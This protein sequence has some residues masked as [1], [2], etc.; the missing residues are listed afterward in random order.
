MMKLETCI[1]LGRSSNSG[2]NFPTKFDIKLIIDDFSVSPTSLKRKYFVN[3]KEYTPVVGDKLYFLP[4]CNVP[5]FKLKEFLNNESATLVKNINKATV[6][7]MSADVFYN[8]MQQNDYC[9]RYEKEDVLAL[10]N[11]HDGDS[12]VI[13]A[14]KASTSKYVMSR[15]SIGNQGAISEVK[16][17]PEC[18]VKDQ[19]SYEQLI[20][21]ESATNMYNQD[22]ILKR[23][24]TG[25]VMSNEDYES[26]QRFF[27]SSDT[28]HHMVAMEMMANSDYQKSCVY[29]HLLILEY[30]DAIYV[31]KSKNHVNF[32][33]LLNFLKISDVHYHSIDKIFDSLIKTK[34]LSRENFN[35]L[36]PLVIDAVSSGRKVTHFKASNVVPDDIILNAM[37]E[38]VLNGDLD[39]LIINEEEIIN[40]RLTR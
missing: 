16:D 34:L 6:T 26:I 8:L 13:N 5:R 2:H 9:Y 7:F 23:I 20:Y 36:E 18:F 37:E 38:S 14:L 22:E 19:K 12:T 4:G 1:C 32:K 40:P 39:T 30:K 24:N 31:C 10:Y 29:L 3:K 33:A 35:I 21:I 28:S 27:K 25:K 11:K 15:S 17:Y